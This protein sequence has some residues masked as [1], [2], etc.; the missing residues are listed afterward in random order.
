MCNSFGC[1]GLD[2]LRG[3]GKS[4]TC[5]SIHSNRSEIVAQQAL[6]SSSVIVSFDVEIMDDGKHI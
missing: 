5:P 3:M 2:D 4:P 6:C 1:C